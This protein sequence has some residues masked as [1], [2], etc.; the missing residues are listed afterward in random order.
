MDDISYDDFKSVDNLNHWR[1]EFE[2]HAGNAPILV[3]MNKSE[4][5]NVPSPEGGFQIAEE[6]GIQVCRI[7]WAILYQ[8]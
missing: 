4:I 2:K 6:E 1:S 3:A 7:F 8:F 5:E